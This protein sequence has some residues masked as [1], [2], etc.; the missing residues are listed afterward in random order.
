[1]S[2]S[3]TTA[4]N[5]TPGVVP[6]GF[7]PRPRNTPVGE[8]KQSRAPHFQLRPHKQWRPH[9]PTLL[10]LESALPIVTLRS[11]VC[12]RKVAGLGYECCLLRHYN[13]IDGQAGRSLNLP[14]RERAGPTFDSADAPTASEP[15]P[16]QKYSILTMPPG[17]PVNGLI[18]PRVYA[19]LYKMEGRERWF[20]NRQPHG[21]RSYWWL[22]CSIH[23][24]LIH[25]CSNVAAKSN[26]RADGREADAGFRYTKAAGT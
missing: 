7:H 16:S 23:R 24:G 11:P 5:A 6:T 13:S 20:R 8:Q 22:I 25:L 9:L 14:L 26:P 1:L 18:T 15:W 2:F 12:C 4:R 10:R 3:R 21:W 17:S 19:G